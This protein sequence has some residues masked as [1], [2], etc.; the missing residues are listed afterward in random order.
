[1]L[2][3]TVD[4][5]VVGDDGAVVLHFRA[6]HDK[7][8]RSALVPISDDTVALLEAA[9]SEQIVEAS[10]WLIPEGRLDYQDARDKPWSKDG[11]I[12]SLH[13]AERALGVS[14]VDGRGYHGLKRRH[15]TTAMEVASGDSALVGDL[16]GNRSRQLLEN[17]YR[18]TSRS[19]MSD[20]VRAVRSALKA[21]ESLPQ[22]LPSAGGPDRPPDDAASFRDVSELARVDSNH[23]RRFQRPATEGRKNAEDGGE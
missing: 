3:L 14:H 13:R 22:H 9:L 10:G 4:D 15:V 12:K 6:R 2:S 21:R 11:A 1:M 20:H 18:K 23:H 17:V 7:G 19:R 8:G 16:T 5:V